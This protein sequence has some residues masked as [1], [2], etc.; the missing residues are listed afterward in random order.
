MAVRGGE[1]GDGVRG[2]GGVAFGA[3]GGAGVM[4]ALEVVGLPGAGDGVVEDPLVVAG[5]VGVREFALGGGGVGGDGGD[6]GDA[7]VSGVCVAAFVV[8]RCF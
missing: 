3:G 6:G 2:H 4:F 1:R 7:A 5:G 8:G